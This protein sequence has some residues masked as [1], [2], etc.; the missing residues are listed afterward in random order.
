MLPLLKTILLLV[1]VMVLSQKVAVGSECRGP[2]LLSAKTCEGDGLEIEEKKLYRMINEYRARHGLPPIPPSPSLN[3]VAN[4][5]VRDLTENHES[6]ARGGL[7]WVHGWSNCPYDANDSRTLYCMW[8][9]PKRL[10]TSYPGMGFEIF[11]GFPDEKYLN[12]TMTADVAF[13]TWEKSPLH[14]EVIL[15]QGR[16]KKYQW[17][18]MGVGIY[19]GYATLWFGEEPDPLSEKNVK[20][21]RITH[22]KKE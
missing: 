10:Q 16:W 8:E 18:A 11:C 5:H 13:R 1:G 21:N 12:F 15:N 19:K 22:L 9:A 3:L 6:Y 4:R 7:H 14:R 17:K 2:N 20:G